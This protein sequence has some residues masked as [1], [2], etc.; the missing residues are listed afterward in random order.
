MSTPRKTSRRLPRRHTL[1]AL[2]TQRDGVLSLENASLR[3]RLEKQVRQIDDL[4]AKLRESLVREANL[5]RRLVTLSEKQQLAA[6]KPATPVSKQEY[7]S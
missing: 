2:L 3:E 6:G 1:G 4:K 5:R 7:Q